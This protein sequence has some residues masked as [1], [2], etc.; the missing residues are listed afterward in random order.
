MPTQPPEPQPLDA[1]IWDSINALAKLRMR[2]IRNGDGL[3]QSTQK[4]YADVL[5]D[6]MRTLADWCDNAR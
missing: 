2:I 4:H 3:K 1:A 5:A 6:W